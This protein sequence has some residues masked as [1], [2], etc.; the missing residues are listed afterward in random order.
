[1]QFP[2]SEHLNIAGFSRLFDNKSECYKL[3]WFQAIMQHVSNGQQEMSFEELT[4]DMIA[5]A[6]T[7]VNEYHL[8]LGPNDTLEKAVNYI[9]SVSGLL[10]S[11]SQ[12][13][14]QDW[15]KTS[16][17]PAVKRFKTTLSLNVPFRL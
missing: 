4:D 11:S 14:I 12:P 16:A 17:D 9:S 8:N 2:Q 5:N 1:M 6:W 3:F 10:P 15:L 7:M 13:L